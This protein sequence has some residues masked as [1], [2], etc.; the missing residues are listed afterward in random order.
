MK[1]KGATVGFVFPDKEK[2]NLTQAWRL[3]LS[4]SWEMP[5]GHFLNGKFYPYWKEREFR[6]ES[7]IE[8]APKIPRSFRGDKLKAARSRRSKV[9]KRNKQIMSRQDISY[10]KHGTKT[11]ASTPAMPL[12]KAWLEVMGHEGKKVE[13][14]IKHKVDQVFERDFSRLGT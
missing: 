14:R 5:A 10:V 13:E 12:Q 7:G 2:L 6:K 8:K 9:T 4:D 1:D 3:E 11:K